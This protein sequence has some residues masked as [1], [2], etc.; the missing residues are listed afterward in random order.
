MIDALELKVQKDIRN[1]LVVKCKNFQIFLIDFLNTNVCLSI[2]KSLDLLSN[3]SKKC[4][5]SNH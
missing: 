1:Q 5:I 4:Y 3:L 2:N